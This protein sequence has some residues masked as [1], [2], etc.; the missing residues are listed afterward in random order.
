MSEELK[1]YIWRDVLCDYTCGIIVAMA[2]NIEDARSV[3]ISSG[4]DEWNH[5]R[6]VRAIEDDPEVHSNPY[7]TYV[8]G[9]G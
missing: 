7:G 4:L 5:T 6:V 1:L 3:V 2:H 8:V 9:G